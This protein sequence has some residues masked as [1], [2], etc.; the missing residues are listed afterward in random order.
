MYEGYFAEPGA[1]FITCHACGHL[2]QEKRLPNDH[3]L[4]CTACG[5]LVARPGQVVAPAPRQR[6]RQDFLG[7]W[8]GLGCVNESC[9]WRARW[10]LPL[11]D[12]LDSARRCPACRSE[13]AWGDGQVEP[14]SPGPGRR[15]QHDRS[16]SRRV[17]AR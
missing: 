14:W 7:R 3:E 5:T 16:R 4:H 10:P 17:G 9:R 1:V 6:D 15:R 13:I 8:L 2:W 12:V 11:L